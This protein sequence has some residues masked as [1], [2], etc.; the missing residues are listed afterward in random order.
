M[1]SGRAIATPSARA[2]AARAEHDA[3]AR[4]EVGTGVAGVGVARLGELGVEHLQEHFGT[5][6]AHGSNLPVGPAMLRA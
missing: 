6:H 2:P 1:P 4:D 5:V 3:L